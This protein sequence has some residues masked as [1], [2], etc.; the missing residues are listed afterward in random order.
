MR[1]LWHNKSFDRLRNL[2]A[3]LKY[4]VFVTTSPGLPYIYHTTNTHMTYHDVNTMA[5]RPYNVS[6]RPIR[7]AYTTVIRLYKTAWS[8]VYI[9]GMQFYIKFARRMLVVD[10]TLITQ[11]EVQISPM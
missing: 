2:P 9:N 6:I 7:M 8:D 11:Q 1:T 10:L 4:V 5:I 3:I